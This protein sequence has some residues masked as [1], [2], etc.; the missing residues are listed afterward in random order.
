MLFFEPV[1]LIPVSI[2]LYVSNMSFTSII[3]H[4]LASVIFYPYGALWFIQAC[5]VGIWILYFFIKNDKVKLIAPVYDGS[6]ADLA[7]CIC[8]L[9]K[10]RSLLQK[11]AKA[12]FEDA[13]KYTSGYAVKITEQTIDAVFANQL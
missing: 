11:F 12:G 9:V 10:D 2:H 8:T 5:L 6:V 1:S 7:R 13:K 3:G 4:V